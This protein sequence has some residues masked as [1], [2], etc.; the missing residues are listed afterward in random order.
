MRSP[1]AAFVVV[2]VLA[3]CA[4]ADGA[5]QPRTY[6]EREFAVRESLPGVY[7]R[8]VARIEGCVSFN[9]LF[10]P[11]QL[12]SRIEPGDERAE[13][14]VVRRTGDA[15]LWGANLQSTAEGTKVVTY[16]ARNESVGQVNAMM[17]AWAENRQLKQ[18]PGVPQFADC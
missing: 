5:A 9:S 16:A 3:G 2:F 6:V 13:I 8:M 18:T 14:A 11:R 15:P 1:A 7:S 10:T 17:R 4:G 12:V